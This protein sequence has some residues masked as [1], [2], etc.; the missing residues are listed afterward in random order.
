MYIYITLLI[1]STLCVMTMTPPLKLRRPSTKQST[2]SK[3]RW[4]VGSSSSSRCVLRRPSST[5]TTRDF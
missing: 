3:S 2:V 4:L 1:S 5:N